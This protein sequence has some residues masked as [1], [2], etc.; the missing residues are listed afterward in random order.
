LGFAWAF[1][2]VVV[3][4]LDGTAAAELLVGARVVVTG[5]AVVFAAPGTVI[6]LVDAAPE[7]LM[8]DAG[9]V[10]LGVAVGRL[11]KGVGSGGK[12]FD[13]IPA[14]ISFRPASDWLW[15]NL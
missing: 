9:V 6:P 4:G 14:I 15:R 1:A 10:A 11:V 12:G 3:T 7:E 5:V 8:P 13:M 2:L